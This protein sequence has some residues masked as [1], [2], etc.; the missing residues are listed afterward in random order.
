MFDTLPLVL[1][2]LVS[3]VLLVGLFRYLKL[4]AMIAYFVVGL[5]LGPHLIGVLPDS[6]SSRHFAEFG[7]VF[8]MFSIGLE[9]SLP[10]LY[11][12]RN[13]LFGLGGAQV[14][15]TLFASIS[16]AWWL[17]LHLTSAFVIG[18][19]FTMSST[20]IVSKILMERVDLNS[21]HGRLAIGIL[22]FQDIAVIPILIL[23]PALG[24]STS[25]I[26]TIFLMSLLKAIFLFSILFKFGRPLMNSWLSLIHI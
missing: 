24:A 19:A 16:L 9:F 12:M 4:P 13:I 1:I 5:I 7:I 8:L 6:E 3:S 15:I 14:F 10:K 26:G 21:R 18:S 20:A 23:I 17:G 2:L 25:D 22:L 11:S